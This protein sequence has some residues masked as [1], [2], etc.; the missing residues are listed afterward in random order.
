MVVVD[1]II[2]QEDGTIEISRGNNFAG[3]D[4]DCSTKQ[5]V[6]KDESCRSYVFED[7]VSFSVNSF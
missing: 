7:V 1:M 6:G 3:I 4:Y 2:K 5:L